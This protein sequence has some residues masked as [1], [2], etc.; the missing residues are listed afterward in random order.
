PVT[1][2]WTIEAW[3]KPSANSNYAAVA[4]GNTSNNGPVLVMTGSN[5]WR[6]AFFGGANATAS[7]VDT[8]AFHHIVGTFDGTSLR[9][10]KDGLLAG[11]PA[12]ASP[13]AA[14]TVS[15][16][17]GAAFGSR[18]F[19]GDIDEVR[20]STTNRSADWIA[21]EYNNQNAPGTFITMGS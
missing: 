10:Y 19:N 16:G 17:I 21:A 1:T 13:A 12:A 15:A 11:G 4:W 9:L 8:T 18:F 14:N 3:A 20:I 7:G 6:T 5:Q 2:P